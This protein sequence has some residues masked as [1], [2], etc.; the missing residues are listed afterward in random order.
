MGPIIFIPLSQKGG[1]IV[2]LGVINR[3]WR[4]ANGQMVDGLMDRPS[5]RA[6]RP[7]NLLAACNLGTWIC[8]MGSGAHTISWGT[9]WAI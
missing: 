4:L 8:G 7:T 9:C 5:D 6:K 3:Y 1:E 2:F